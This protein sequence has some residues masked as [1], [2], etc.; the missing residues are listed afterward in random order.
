MIKRKKEEE[1][2]LLL[3]RS[4]KDLEDAAKAIAKHNAKVDKLRKLCTPETEKFLS[5]YLYIYTEIN[6]KLIK[7]GK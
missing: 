2:G 6:G 4:F 3:R 1:A 5:T 7:V